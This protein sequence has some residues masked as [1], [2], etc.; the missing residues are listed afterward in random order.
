LLFGVGNFLEEQARVLSFGQWVRQRRKALDLT[1]EQLAQRVSCSVSAIR[2]FETA[3]RRPSRQIA[4]QLAV[5]LDIPA[6]QHEV[7]LKAARAE[8]GEIYLST[9]PGATLPV[10]RAQGKQAAA[11]LSQPPHLAPAASAR[12]S[13]PVQGT[14]LVG[15]E[16][17]LAKIYQLLR[18]PDCR[19][20]TLTG[21]GGI[22]KTRLAIQTANQLSTLPAGDFPDGVYFVP[23]TPV[24]TPEAIVPAIAAALEIPSYDAGEPGLQFNNYL[25]HKKLLLL[26]D[27]ME[28]LIGASGQLA[29][30]LRNAPGVK[31]LVTSRERLNIQAEWVFEIHGLPAPPDEWIEQ[32]EEYSAI[33]LFLQNARRVQPGYIPDRNDL[34][35]ILQI[36]RL[37][38][39][40]P[41][42]IELAASWMRLL[43]PPEI[44]QE[45]SRDL[46]F[47]TSSLRDIPERHRSMRAAFDYSWNLLSEE[48][49]R[50]LMSLSIF[51]GSFTRQAAAAITDAGLTLLSAL[52]DKS[53][54]RTASPGRYDLHELIGAYAAD[55]LHS[56]PGERLQIQARFAAYY[57]GFLHDREEQIF[58]SPGA[59][60]EVYGALENIRM[61]WKW[62]VQQGEV[63]LLEKSLPGLAGFYH[64]AGLLREGESVLG[65]TLKAL[66]APLSTG[67]LNETA[68]PRLLGKLSAEWSRFLNDRAR[69]DDA[70][71][72]AQ[73]AIQWG[74]AT[75]DFASQVKGHL[76]WGQAF[77]RQLNYRAARQQIEEALVLARAAGLMRLEADCLRRL[78]AVASFQE[79]MPEAMTAFEQALNIYQSCSDRLGESLVMKAIGTAYYLR[80]DYP[81]AGA[82]YE[83]ALDLFRSIGDRRNEGRTLNNLGAVCQDR[84][85]Y[86][87]AQV[88]YEGA[89]RLIRETGDPWGES[90]TLTNLG[91]VVH[92]LGIFSN[93]QEYYEASLQLCQAIGEWGGEAGNLSNLGLL[94]Y[95]QGRYAAAQAYQEQALG[96]LLGHADARLEALVRT[97][98]G[99]TR[100]AQGQLEEAA[101]NQ[102][103]QAGQER[104]AVE[105]QAGLARLHLARRASSL[106]NAQVAQILAVLNAMPGFPYDLGD[107]VYSIYMACFVVLQA[108]ND[109][110]AWQVLSTAHQALQEQVCQ[111]QDAVLREHFVQNFPDRRAI[112]QAQE[113][114]T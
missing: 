81:Q 41:L 28:H 70:M 76:Q 89:L 112:L 47:L 78:G 77:F 8:G 45:I 109:D 30:I 51:P 65:A 23:L 87:R 60:A 111:V 14:P 7:F 27:N 101:V 25:H 64:L 114:R 42:G 75:Q 95:H 4:A 40:V 55:K 54:L 66:R 69:Y 15:R 83:T 72:A 108:A 113:G 49:Q 36:C 68:L 104:L 3:E 39:G 90:A 29:E 11:S 2:K 94:A 26:L 99:W 12:S 52:V 17:E 85:E 44:A 37:M 53:L 102:L 79:Q 58:R 107:D 91:T 57:L 24:V 62:A 74:Q 88:Y 67:S 97:R 98:Q 10:L 59:V 84:G 20:L 93:A 43:T 71:R 5:H 18:N 96:V 38:N 105:P 21:P 103:Q 110:R 80:G 46:D 19:L 86:I 92:R 32:P 50:G 22:G 63:D 1:Q 61:A 82:R 73:E 34:A 13:L 9:S 48:E 106:A 16:P 35:A 100:L 6:N 56:D 33:A 31:M